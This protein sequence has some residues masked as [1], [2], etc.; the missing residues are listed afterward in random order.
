[1]FENQNI[2]EDICEG[3]FNKRRTE[4]RV[5]NTWSDIESST[6]QILVN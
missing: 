5:A 1:M 2:L 4:Q 3:A 6:S